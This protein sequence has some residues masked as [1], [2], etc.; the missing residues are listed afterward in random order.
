VLRKGKFTENSYFDPVNHEIISYG[1]NG[2]FYLFEFT[3]AS[4]V[5]TFAGVHSSIVVSAVK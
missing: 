1:Y 2:D 4:N 3:N 5:I